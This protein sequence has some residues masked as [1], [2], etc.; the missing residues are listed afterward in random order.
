VIDGGVY[1]EF[2][3]FSPRQKQEMGQE[4]GRRF[5]VAGTLGIWEVATFL[6]RLL[7]YSA[8]ASQKANTSLTG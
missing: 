6:F 2:R 3:F 1:I 8:W 7:S 4:T 5:Q